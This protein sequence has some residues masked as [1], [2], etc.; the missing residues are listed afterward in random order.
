M[1]QVKPWEHYRFDAL[2]E[3]ARVMVFGENY[4]D[5]ESYSAYLHLKA[6]R[7]PILLRRVVLEG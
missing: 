2:V 5:S 6:M 3:A 7:V 4:L 1:A